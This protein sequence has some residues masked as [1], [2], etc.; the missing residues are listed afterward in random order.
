MTLARALD[1]VSMVVSVTLFLIGAVDIVFLVMD[2][3]VA[4]PRKC[5]LF[6]NVNFLA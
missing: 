6:G 3:G 1:V 5:Q 2:G 4:P